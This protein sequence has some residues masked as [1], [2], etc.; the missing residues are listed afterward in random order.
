MRQ[1]A[2][3]EATREQ[4]IAAAAVLFGQR[5]YAATTIDDLARAANLARATLYY[6]FG[7]KEAVVLALAQRAVAQA[8]RRAAERLADGGS[9]LE[10]LSSFL[11]EVAETAERDRLLARVYLAEMFKL[12]RLEAAPNQ[13]QPS[14]R[15]L[16][17]HLFTA[18]QQAGQVRRD[19][20]PRELGHLA[21]FAFLGAQLSWLEADGG[22][23]LRERTARALALLLDGLRGTARV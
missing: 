14:V 6:H 20:E 8:S 19:V 16:L 11:D 2:R 13:E 3:R 15:R 12:P 22:P 7:S 4:I 5:G 9:P 10:I 17:T 21:A 18:A 1:V 23:S